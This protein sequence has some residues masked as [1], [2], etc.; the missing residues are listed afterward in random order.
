MS[1]RKT[2]FLTGFTPDDFFQELNDV[3]R[4]GTGT[5]TLSCMARC[6]PNFGPGGSLSGGSPVGF[7]V[8]N[9]DPLAP[10]DGGFTINGTFAGVTTLTWGD[11]TATQTI[12]ANGGTLIGGGA[13]G[14]STLLHA[15]FHPNG[16]V[17]LW[18]NG[19]LAETF[20]NGDFV[21]APASTPT[22]VGILE[23]PGVEFFG[24]LGIAGLAIVDSVLDPQDISDHYNACLESDRF[25][26]TGVY[27]ALWDVRTG[28][29]DI[30]DETTQWF[31]EVSAQPLDRLTTD[32]N[33]SMSVGSHKPRFQ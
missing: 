15:R 7:V 18:F 30:T 13:E 31:D 6:F 20:L 27:D 3:L 25:F 8:D 10:E 4:G 5:F 19:T 26:D 11:G 12:T 14:A 32:D 24:G 21:P 28:L 1:E 23:L 2:S 29:P 9:T 16:T 33:F 17:D 22:N